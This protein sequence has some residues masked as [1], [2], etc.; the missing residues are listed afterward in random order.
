MRRR[1]GDREP[2]P[3]RSA[4]RYE[5]TALPARRYRVRRALD[6][7]HTRYLS[8]RL[9]FGVAKHARFEIA[10]LNLTQIDTGAPFPAR[11]T[12]HFAN[13]YATLK[14]NVDFSTLT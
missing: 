14:L 7:S 4:L 1:A 6:R 12:I 5:R 2:I 8:R 13:F 11:N 10:A 9:I 3:R